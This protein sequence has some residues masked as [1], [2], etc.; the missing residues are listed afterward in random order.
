MSEYP[1]VNNWVAGTSAYGRIVWGST[2]GNKFTLIF[3]SVTARTLGG[4][5]RDMTREWDGTLKCNV[6][7]YTLSGATTIGENDEAVLI[8]E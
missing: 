3:P 2:A 4:A 1:W 5:S 8:Y 7:E 6:G